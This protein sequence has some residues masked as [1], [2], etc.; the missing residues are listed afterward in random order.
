MQTCTRTCVRFQSITAITTACFFALILLSLSAGL[1]AAESSATNTVSALD[2]N[3]DPGWFPTRSI[4]LAEA[5]A[6]GLLN[7]N[8]ATVEELALALPGIGPAKAQL[9]VDWRNAN[10][11]FQSLEQLV[12]V[13]GIGVKTLEKIRPFIQLGSAAESVSGKQPSVRDAQHRWVLLDIVNQANK[14]AEQARLELEGG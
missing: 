11:A 3:Q 12:E 10:G 8:S 1:K 6:S 2:E 5:Q 4:P 7:I 9:I 14:D 13:N